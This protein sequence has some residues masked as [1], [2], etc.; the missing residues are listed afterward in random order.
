MSDHNGP[1]NSTDGPEDEGY[2]SR[3]SGFHRLAL[4]ERVALLASLAGLTASES[5]TLTGAVGDDV[6]QADATL[7]NVVGVL[8]MP[9]G[10][11][12]N[13]VVNGRDVLVPMAIEEPSVVAALSNGALMVR[14]SGGVR[15]ACDSPEMIGQIQVYDLPDPEGASARLH[16]AQVDLIALVNRSLPGMVARGGGA[17][18]LEIRAIGTAMG[19]MLVVHL[20]VDVCDAMGANIVNGAVELLAPEVAAITGGRLG[21]RVLSNLADRRLARANCRVP[22]ASLEREGA[23]GEQAAQG[24][25]T[26]QA[27]AEAD[28]YRAATHNKGIMN[29]IDAVAVATGNDWRALEAGAHAYAARGGQYGPL[30]TW[31][32]HVSGDLV[33]SIELPLAVGTQGAAV[34]A[35]PIAALAQKIMRVTT[36]VELAEVMAAVGLVQNLAALRALAVEGIQQGHMRLHARQMAVAAGAQEAEVDELAQRMV[37]EGAIGFT[38]ARELIKEMYG[39]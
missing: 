26:A 38:R 31:T 6:R 30:T 11:G 36:S 22:A 12:T 33:G 24:I 14:E 9:L 15:A 39:R 27:L 13:L 1:T 10:I 18:S 17:R 8:R 25:L 20:I 35:H 5:A 16:D 4:E 32:R 3:L 28:P 2:T 29:G 37:D 34:R 23:T 7:E 19:S 21:V